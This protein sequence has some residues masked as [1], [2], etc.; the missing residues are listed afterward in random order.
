M[1]SL[2]HSPAE[3]LAPQEP[4]IR[5]PS[6]AAIKDLLRRLDIHDE[7]ESKHFAMSTRSFLSITKQLSDP[8][9]CRLSNE[10]LD[11]YAREFLEARST[12]G[13]CGNVSI[14]LKYWPSGEY[15]KKL[16]YAL[17]R[18]MIVTNVGLIMVRQRDYKRQALKASTKRPRPELT[19]ISSDS[20]DEAP[21]ER[22]VPLASGALPC[23]QGE[24]SRNHRVSED[25]VPISRTPGTAAES[26]QESFTSCDISEDE[27][28][29]T[30]T[31]SDL[32][33]HPAHYGW[34]A[35]AHILTKRARAVARARARETARAEAEAEAARAAEESRKSQHH[36]FSPR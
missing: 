18:E 26:D 22:L 31:R 8:E 2:V 16:N 32:C 34:Q 25:E 15:Q 6:S 20:E 19:D 36:G 30:S 29:F 3:G 33:R 7:Y 1:S 35:P 17:N 11:D 13:H 28:Y 9:I 14:G 10:Q 24:V 5:R 21:K 4:G 12:F 23:E 27:A